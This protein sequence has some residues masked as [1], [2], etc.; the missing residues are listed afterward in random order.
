MVNFSIGPPVNRTAY[1]CLYQS[2]AKINCM[3]TMLNCAH[4]Q[5]LQKVISSFFELLTLYNL[6]EMNHLL[7]YMLTFYIVSN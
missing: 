5:V 3:K 6:S 7:A 2:D 1:I 4:L